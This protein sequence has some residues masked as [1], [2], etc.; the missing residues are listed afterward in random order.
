[1]A[2]LLSTDPVD[3]LLDNTGDLVFENG[4]LQLATGVVG[5]AQLIREAILLVRG[6]WFLDLDA[7]TPWFEREGVSADDALLG[8]VFNQVKSEAAIRSAIADVPGVG[9]INSVS[10][11]Y[12]NATRLMTVTWNVTTVFGDTVA[13][14]LTREI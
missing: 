6:E 4:D 9:T 11:T 13:D 14:S 1:M 10:A 8:E 7:G 12:D 3:L 2:S 5:V